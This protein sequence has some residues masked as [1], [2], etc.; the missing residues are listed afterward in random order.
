[1]GTPGHN[2]QP[3]NLFLLEVR[4]LFICAVYFVGHIVCALHENIFCLRFDHDL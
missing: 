3:S 1:M 4:L 2:Q